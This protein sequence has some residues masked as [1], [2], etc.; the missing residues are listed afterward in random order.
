MPVAGEIILFVTNFDLMFVLAAD[1]LQPFRIRF[2]VI[3][4]CYRPG[5]CQ[6]IVDCRGLVPE[7]VRIC[8]VQKYTLVHNGRVVCMKRDTAA[9]VTSGALYLAS[10][11]GQNVKGPALF[12]A[13]PFANGIAGE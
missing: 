2:P 1:C 10:L 7:N 5:P 12:G 4:S 8:L 9:V 6:C 13:F 3:D 11:Y